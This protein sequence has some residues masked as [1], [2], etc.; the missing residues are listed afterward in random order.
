MFKKLKLKNRIYTGFITIGLISLGM[1]LVSI[2]T[3]YYAN[4]NF[5]YFVQSSSKSHLALSISRDVLEIQRQALIYTHEGHQSAADRMHEIYQRISAQIKQE[6]QQDSKYFQEII[7]HLDT[8]VETFKQVQ[9]QR[10]RQVTLVNTEIRSLASEAENHFLKHIEQTSSSADISAQLNNQRILSS[11]LL[12]EK[13][14]MRYFDLLDSKDIVLAK[15]SIF[16]VQNSLHALQKQHGA[17]LTAEHILQTIQ[18]MNNYEQVFLEAVQRTRGYLILV[19]VVMSAEAYEIIY[20]SKRMGRQLEQEMNMIEANTLALMQQVITI[21][22]LSGATFLILIT[23]FSILI[24]RSITKPI[25]RLTDTFIALAKGS[26]QTKIPTYEIQDEIGALTK[27]A[28]VFK[29]K[30]KQTEDLLT[31]SKQLTADLARSNDELEQFVYTVSHD[32]KSPLVTSMGFIGIIQ[33]LATA[34]KMEEAVGKLDRVVNAN[35]R[36]GQL[37]NDLL[38]LSRVGR[39][40]TDKTA[41][42]LNN[43]LD[44]FRKNHANELSS[45]SFT[46]AFDSEFPTLYAN[47]SRILQVF[48]N[49]LG[50]ALKYATN[51]N[52]SVINIGASEAEENHLIYFKDNGPGIDKAYHKKIFRL[53]YRLNNEM[54]G[55]GIGL[56]VAAKVMKFHNGSI[57]VE[58]KPNNGATFWLKFPKINEETKQ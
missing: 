41:I 48:E 1:A 20:R 19:N 40:D 16:R 11:L 42:D 24:S 21:M 10:T 32:L 9:Q 44:G 53:F 30:N 17:Q 13:Y 2:V 54:E 3:F 45:S 43:L 55:T 4:D 52:G 28:I 12:I 14:A 33:K 15:E 39:I 29:E 7:K 18:Y 23:L 47:E 38:E 36:M 56:A 5:S 49:L 51:P 34:G 37:I 22:L 58:S 8:Y 57:W 35:R 46:L 6:N 31:Q 25:A 50:N 26:H 27:A